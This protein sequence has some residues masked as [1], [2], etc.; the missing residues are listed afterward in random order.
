MIGF[1]KCLISQYWTITSKADNDGKSKLPNISND[2]VHAPIYLQRTV[3][4]VSDELM[5]FILK[6]I[7]LIIPYSSLPQPGNSC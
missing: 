3:S 6:S 2:R 5:L 7:I 4:I 1:S